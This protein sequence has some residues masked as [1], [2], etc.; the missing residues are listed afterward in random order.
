[1]FTLITDSNLRKYL[2]Y[3]DYIRRLNIIRSFGKCRIIVRD[4]HDICDQIRT[5]D[6][7]KVL[8]RDNTISKFEIA[9]SSDIPKFCILSKKYMLNAIHLKQSDFENV[10]QINLVK[11]RRQGISIGTSVHSSQEYDI[12][13]LK[14]P[15][16]IL[17][18][19]I[20]LTKCKLGVNTIAENE[21]VYILKKAKLDYVETVALGGI[22]YTDVYDEKVKE[23]YKKFSNFAIRSLFYESEDL[24]KD[25]EK[26]MGVVRSVD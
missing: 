20:F 10:S 11:L 15:N 8:Y 14:N 22:G 1:M 5:L 26:L 18:S 25:L 3:G 13:V 21:L 19:P 6:E 23:R 2:S 17:I 16:Y 12:S 4:D 24:A 9:I 7:L